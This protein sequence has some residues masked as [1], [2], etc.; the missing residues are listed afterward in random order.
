[1]SL[2][3]KRMGC[4]GTTNKVTTPERKESKMRIDDLLFLNSIC[5]NM[6]I[7]LK[8]KNDDTVWRMF[9]FSEL[10][11]KVL[12]QR[13][14]M[15]NEGVLT[16]GKVVTRLPDE[17]ECKALKPA[18]VVDTVTAETF[19]EE[20]E[21]LSMQSANTRPVLRSKLLEAFANRVPITITD[22]HGIAYSGR[23]A[24][25]E[26]EDGSGYCFNVTLEC[27]FTGFIRTVK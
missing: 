17:I 11:N 3:V 18:G 24:S 22:V 9:S 20:L 2:D 12:I 19:A 26:H 21:V 15:G 5:K 1:M 13:V 14:T 8:C 25:L 6:E 4:T 23:I 10:H 16:F 27:G 7:Y